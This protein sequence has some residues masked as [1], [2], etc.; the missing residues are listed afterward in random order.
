MT[1][2]INRPRGDPGARRWGEFELL[3]EIGRGAFGAVYRS[4]HPTLQQE[5]AL[6]R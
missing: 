2:P 5:V 4:H 1:I 3:D 6:K